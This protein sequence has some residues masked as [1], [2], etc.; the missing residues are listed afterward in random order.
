VAEGMVTREQLDQAKLR[1]QATGKTV[2]STL[3]EMGVISELVKNQVLKKKFGIE[4][5]LIDTEKREDNVFKLLPKR[6]AGRH[7]ALPLRIENDQLVVAMEEPNNVL[8]VDYLKTLTG[9][10]IQP[11]AASAADLDRALKA[12]PDDERQGIDIS[13]K[14]APVRFLLKAFFS[15]LY[16]LVPALLFIWLY[17]DIGESQ[18]KVLQMGQY[19]IGFYTGL[20]WGAWALL[21]WYIQGLIFASPPPAPDND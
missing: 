8:V 21:V 7:R 4:S 6:E 15:V 9:H 2:S 3:V 13:D 11:V 18:A 10:R 16:F 5:V 14:P 1:H 20:L 12:Y 19:E 17:W